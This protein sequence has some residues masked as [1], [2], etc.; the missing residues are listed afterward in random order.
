MQP[1]DISYDVIIAGAGPVGLFLAC[2]LRLAG[3]SV[4]VLE[5]APDPH[6]QL[7]GLPLGLRGLSVPTIESLDRRDLL[8]QLEERTAS[9]DTQA[10]AHWMQQQRRPAGHFAGIQFFQDQVDA[11][12]WTYRLPGPVGS[13]AA[14][15]A[16]I[17]AVFCERAEALGAGIRR[18][19]GIEAVNVFDTGVTVRTA[20]AAFAGRW[21]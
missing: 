1:L 11:A 2:E 8:G 10:A 16:S 18:G 20:D 5:R 17:E 12:H 19:A 9:K 14:N 13:V 3:V 4:L 21:L 7:K 15:M 6:S